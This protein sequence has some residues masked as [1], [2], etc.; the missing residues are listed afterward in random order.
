MLCT[1]IMLIFICFGGTAP[2]II[3]C[4]REPYILI[5]NAPNVRVLYLI[6]YTINPLVFL[7][8]SALPTMW[9]PV[10]TAPSV[11]FLTFH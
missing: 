10:L 8:T 2:E 4:I 11:A 3:A 7:P 5:H 6:N 9:L 1:I